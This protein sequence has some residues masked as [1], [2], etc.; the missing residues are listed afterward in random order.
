[1]CYFPLV[2]KTVRLSFG[3]ILVIT[4][5]IATHIYYDH[6]NNM[7]ITLVKHVL[8]QITL[9]SVSGSTHVLGDLTGSRGRNIPAA[10]CCLL[11]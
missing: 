7:S 4:W 8:Y 2:P 3:F 5:P 10:H 11:N 9:T 1:M 6:Q